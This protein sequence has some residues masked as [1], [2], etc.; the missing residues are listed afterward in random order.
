[1]NTPCPCQSSLDYNI[2]CGRY[3]KGKLFAPTAEALMRSRYSAYSLKLGRYLFKTW[4]K[5]TRPELQ[6]LFQED[7]T[8]WLV[9]QQYCFDG[10]RAIQ[11]IQDKAWFEANGYSLGE[12]HN[13]VL[14]ALGCSLR[15]SQK[16]VI[17]VVVLFV[18][19]ATIPCKARLVAN[20]F[21]THCIHQNNIAGVPGLKI[22]KTE[23]GMPQDDTGIVAF[24]ATYSRQKQIM[25][26]SERSYF[27]KAN[28]RW[29]YVDAV[30]E[31]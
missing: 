17:H 27:E 24:V 10:Y 8:E 13:A 18:K 20:P 14:D 5:S 4:H 11:S 7:D 29:V 15:V 2:C 21:L 26:L 28:G 25:Q 19:G 23:Q 1:M 22:V 6:S 12:S 3:H 9:L 16:R 30:E 31:M